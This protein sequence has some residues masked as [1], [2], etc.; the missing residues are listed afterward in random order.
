MLESWQVSC[1][2]VLCRIKQ[3]EG[4]GVGKSRAYCNK[5]LAI[6][7][8]AVC[9]T[10][11]AGRQLERQQSCAKSDSADLVRRGNNG[12]G[13]HMCVLKVETKE[14]LLKRH[15]QA[16]RCRWSKGSR[17]RRSERQV[18]AAGDTGAVST[19]PLCRCPRSTCLDSRHIRGTWPCEVSL[20]TGWP[21]LLH[22]RSLKAICFLI[23]SQLCCASGVLFWRPPSHRLTRRQTDFRFHSQHDEA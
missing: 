22:S 6:D 7:D 14:A 10:R 3:E 19:L 5:R 23:P 11:H 9:T 16:L 20:R 13:E 17:G 2:A 21:L 12:G 1:Q 4:Y 18:G 8:V 15:A